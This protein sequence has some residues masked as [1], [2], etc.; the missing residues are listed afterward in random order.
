[1][2]A[3]PHQLEMGKTHDF[4]FKNNSDRTVLS[5]HFMWCTDFSKDDL[6]KELIYGI[7]KMILR[8]KVIICFLLLQKKKK[9]LF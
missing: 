6:T 4:V 3:Q 1:M 2:S 9:P 7:F 5:F 8:L